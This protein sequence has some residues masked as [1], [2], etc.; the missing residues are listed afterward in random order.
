ME[1]IKGKMRQCGADRKGKCRA[2]N[3][4]LTITQMN[5]KTNSPW[6]NIMNRRSVYPLGIA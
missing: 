5:R 3:K 6:G 1:T 4:I 2:K